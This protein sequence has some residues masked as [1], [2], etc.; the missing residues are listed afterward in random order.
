MKKMLVLTFTEF[1]Q[2]GQS[3]S[4][5]IE[6]NLNVTMNVLNSSL[7]WSFFFKTFTT[8]SPYFLQYD[9]RINKRRLNRSIGITTISQNKRAPYAACMEK[10]DFKTQYCLHIKRNKK[11]FFLKTFRH[12]TYCPI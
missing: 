12:K 8:N 5:F 7:N 11:H 3:C 10:K 4:I 9:S 2:N 1:K 6:K